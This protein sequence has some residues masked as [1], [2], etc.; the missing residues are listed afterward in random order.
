MS[1]TT[2]AL[3]L[4]SAL[5][6]V[7]SGCQ[8]WPRYLHVGDGDD[9]QTITERFVV[10]ED[11][12]LGATE[13]QEL[14]EVAPGTE[15]LFYGFIHTC[16]KDDAA[17]WPQWPLHDYDDNE[18]GVPDG[19]VA[20]NSGWY[21]GDVDWLGFVVTDTAVLSGAMEW[22]NSPSADGAEAQGEE[23]S[24]LDFV[25]FAESAGEMVLVN[26]SGVTTSYPETLAASSR[27]DGGTAVAIAV[28]CHHT[29][30][31]DYDLRL[32]LH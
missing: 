6:L 9:G 19:Q 12:A 4:L 26:E 32:V 17:T 25:I 14:G 11:E 18:D 5:G 15:I 24:D 1:Q 10:F 30:P 31:T 28:A 2:L 3:T 22:T 8:D 7:I 27:F 16:G 23:V 13:I 29:L 20:Y 21:T